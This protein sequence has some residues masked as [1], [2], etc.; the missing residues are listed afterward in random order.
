MARVQATTKPWWQMTR[1]PAPGF[2]LGGLWL[3]LGALR[4]V[5]LEPGGGWI[6]PT[7]AT[8][9]TLGGLAYLAGSTAVV[10]RRRAPAAEPHD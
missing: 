4:W 6:A 9:F 5:W 1:T 8:V 10:L 3:L 2:V 7:A